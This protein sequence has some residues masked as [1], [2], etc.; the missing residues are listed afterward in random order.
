M[1]Q[2]LA[3]YF[4]KAGRVAPS[5]LFQLVFAC[6]FDVVVIGSEVKLNVVLGGLL[7]FG[8]N[9]IIAILKCFKVVV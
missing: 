3:Y 7:I 8:S 1:S 6:I 5:T 4:E 2:T 9:F